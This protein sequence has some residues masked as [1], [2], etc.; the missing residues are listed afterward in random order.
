MDTLT[1]KLSAA[2]AAV[3][4]ATMAVVGFTAVAAD[5]RA[6]ESFQVD[7]HDVCRSQYAGNV[8]GATGVSA[9]HL[10]CYRLNIGFSHKGV[11]PSLTFPGAPDIGAYC[12]ERYGSSAVPIMKSHNPITGWWC[13]RPFQFPVGKQVGTPK[14][15]KQVGTPRY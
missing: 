4:I 8:V 1:R 15:G 14:V 6:T 9:A 12:T 10:I 7:I 13:E 3:I 2:V 5:A 11:G